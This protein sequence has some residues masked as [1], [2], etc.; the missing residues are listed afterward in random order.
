MTN[1]WLTY[2]SN[3][4]LAIVGCLFA[5]SIFMGLWSGVLSVAPISCAAVAAYTCVQLI[6]KLPWLPPAMLPIIGL[7]VGSLLAYISSFVFLHLSSHYLAFS[8][9][10]SV[11][12]VRVIA[13]NFDVMTGG[14]LGTAVPRF[15]D[16]KDLV[17]IL[18]VVSFAFWRV[19]R[20]RF[21][22]S[23]EAV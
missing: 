19:R 3:I 15:V 17:L 10:A 21:G 4:E 20:S 6:T 5:L 14:V 7:L 12:L 13:L 2:E 11:V 18:V 22:L 23:L 16:T 8:T 1:F 9:I